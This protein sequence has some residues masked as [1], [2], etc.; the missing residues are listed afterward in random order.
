MADGGLLP[1]RELGVLRRDR[2]DP[3]LDG[4]VDDVDEAGRL[5]A[6]ALEHLAVLAEHVA[7]GD[8]DR[9]GRRPEPARQLAHG[10]HHRQ[11]LGLGRADDVEHAVGA[12]PLDAID[13]AGEVAGGVREG[14]GPAAHDQRER[15]PV[16]VRVPGWEHDLGPVG[17]L[18]QAGGGEA[19]EHLGHQ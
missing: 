16:A 9:L 8:V 18:Q 3:S 14:A 17:L 15:F 11:V 10:E 2:S 6:A 5:A 1:G 19:L 7:E 13:D 4:F 12:D